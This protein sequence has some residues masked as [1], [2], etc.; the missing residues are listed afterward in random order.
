MSDNF[1]W[2]NGSGGKP[3]KGSTKEPSITPSIHNDGGTGYRGPVSGKS[4]YAHNIAPVVLAAGISALGGIASS[5]I[6]K[7]K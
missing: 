1:T 7:K 3:A 4:T 5:V 2:L 6:N